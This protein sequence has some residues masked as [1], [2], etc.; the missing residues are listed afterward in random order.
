MLISELLYTYTHVPIIIGGTL[1]T[2]QLTHTH[3][4]P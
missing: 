1:L 3:P 4:T 2:T